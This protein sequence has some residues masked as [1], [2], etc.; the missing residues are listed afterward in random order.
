MRSNKA[1]GGTLIKHGC[2]TITDRLTGQP[3]SSPGSDWP[4]VLSLVAH[5]LRGPISLIAGHLE[6]LADREVQAAPDRID[7]ILE[8]VRS[9]LR[10]LNRLTSELMEARRAAEGSLPIR[11]EEVS[12]HSLIDEVVQAAIPLCRQRNVRLEAEGAAVEGYVIGDPFYLKICLLNLIDNAAKYGKP[13]GRVQLRTQRLGDLMEF[14]VVDEGPG[15][16]ARAGELFTPFVQ[17][18]DA[19]EGIGLGLSLVTAIVT[20]HGG[21]LVWRSGEDSTVGFYLPW[22]ARSGAAG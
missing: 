21:S 18:P 22:R 3:P 1:P 15:L 10:E 4:Q 14:D 7:A 20:A 11:H 9:C 17:G 16:G 19:K 5:Q 6:M 12:I 13:G 2:S 8:E